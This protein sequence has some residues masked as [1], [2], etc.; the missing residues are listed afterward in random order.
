MTDPSAQTNDEATPRKRE[1]WLTQTVLSGALKRSAWRWAW[2][3][4]TLLLVIYPILN[5]LG[6]AKDTAS[7]GFVSGV[8]SSIGFFGLAFFLFG[9]WKR[10]RAERI[11]I[12]IANEIRGYEERAPPAQP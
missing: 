5:W 2:L 4:L 3:G 9:A 1:Q 8:A 10:F 7:G 11:A 6:P 12:E